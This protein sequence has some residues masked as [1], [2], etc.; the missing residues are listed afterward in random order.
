MDM[1]EDVANAASLRWVDTDKDVADPPKY[2]FRVAV[3][4]TKKAMKKSDVRTAV[5]LFSGM[6]PLERVKAFLSLFLS[7]NQEEAK[8]K[9]T[10]AMYGIS[11]AHSILASVFRRS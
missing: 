3:R 1:D 11:R 9:R 4:E 8:D 5:E 6:P 2:R 7:Y 10:L